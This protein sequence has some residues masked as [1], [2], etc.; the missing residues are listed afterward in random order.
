MTTQDER[1]AAVD[2]RIRALPEPALPPALAA[3]VGVLARAAL[4]EGRAPAGRAAGLATT[5]AVVSAVGL[6]L[7]W[8]VRFLSTLAQG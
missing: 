5:A 6:Y 2:Q 1:G 4:A 3:R 7:S 8:A